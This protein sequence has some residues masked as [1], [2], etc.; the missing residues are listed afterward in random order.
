MG[1]CCTKEARGGKL[2]AQEDNLKDATLGKNGAITENSGKP[3]TAPKADNPEDALFNEQMLN[4]TSQNEEVNVQ[5]KKQTSLR[6]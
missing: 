4:I 2:D 6:K 3:I 1:T 5:F